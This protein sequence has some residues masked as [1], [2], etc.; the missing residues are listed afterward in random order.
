MNKKK[1]VV[2]QSDHLNSINQ[3][4]DTSLLLALEAQKRGYKIYYY[5]TKSL[6]FIGGKIMANIKELKLFENKQK[7]Y[8]VINQKFFDLSKANYILMRQNPPF[9]MDYINA[10]FFLERLPKS[11]KVINNPTS[12]R[13]ISEKFYSVNFLKYM[14][15]TIFTKN[16]DQINKFLKKYKEIV[17]KPIHGYGGKNILFIKKTLNKNKILNYIN[18]FDHVMVQKFIPEVIKGDKRVFIID[19]LVRGAIKRVPKKGSYLSNLGQGG[20]AIKT[21]LN[22][23]ELKISKIVA[24]N[25]RNK[26]IFFAGIDFVS[27][28]LIG[29]INVTSPTGLKNFK[30]LSGVNLAKDFWTNLEKLK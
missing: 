6:S 15:P 24:K 30:D 12:V 10:T 13:S 11:V 5:E 23:K 27:N 4:T 22:Q 29:D 1:I 2:L 21:K 16:I 25:L 28:Y 14:P 26:N 19:G 3:D 8:K 18:K 20:L 9:N 17:I 7:F